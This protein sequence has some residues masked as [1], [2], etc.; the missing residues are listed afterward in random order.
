[1]AQ[2]NTRSFSRL[3]RER[4]RQLKLTQQEVARRINTSNVYIGHLEAAKRHPSRKVV[5]E[6]AEALGLDARS[7]VLVGQPKSWFRHFRTAE[8]GRSLYLGYFRQ[9]REGPQKNGQAVVASGENCSKS[10]RFNAGLRPAR[11]RAVNMKAPLWK[12]PTRSESILPAVGM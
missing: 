11:T 1:M 10:R 7:F 2:A 3:I 12:M 5:V 6:L 8:V 4:R 9:G